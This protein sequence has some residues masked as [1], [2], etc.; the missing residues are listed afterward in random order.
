MYIGKKVKRREKERIN[1]RIRDSFSTN[2]TV[3]IA[4]EKKWTK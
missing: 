4:K 2:G 3:N 1:E